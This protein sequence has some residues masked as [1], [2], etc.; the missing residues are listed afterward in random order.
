MSD[1]RSLDIDIS[2]VVAAAGRARMPAAAYVVSDVSL[3]PF[4][5]ASLAPRAAVSRLM[6]V[7]RREVERRLVT[8][9]SA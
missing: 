9:G 7:D 2:R 8:K 4:K 6:R 5:K 1:S 3:L